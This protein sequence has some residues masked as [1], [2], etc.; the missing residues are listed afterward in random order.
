[1]AVSMIR[2]AIIHVVYGI[3]ICNKLVNVFTLKE[4]W[5]T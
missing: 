2:V 5:T 1:M 3:K 4:N